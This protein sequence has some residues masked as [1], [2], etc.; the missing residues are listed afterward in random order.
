MAGVL[1][2][3]MKKKRII[4]VICVIVISIAVGY[5]WLVAAVDWE[6]RSMKKAP[7]GSV[8]AF[9]MQGMSDATLAPYGDHIVIVPPYKIL[10]QYYV[11]PVFAG[12]CRDELE[13]KWIDRQTL[14]IT[15]INE[16]IAENIVKKE[17]V[18][19]GK[20]IKYIF[21]DTAS[22][23]NRLDPTGDKTGSVLH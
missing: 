11:S 15:C 3:K 6:E 18:A 12:Y 7:D 23:N 16:E 14:Q 20:Q 2:N 19:Y 4:L 10:G 5:E 1:N 8:T 9:Y 22:Q 21:K 13:Y 17:T